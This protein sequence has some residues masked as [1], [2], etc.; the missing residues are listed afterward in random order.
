MINVKAYF[1][2]VFLLLMLSSVGCETA[3]SIKGED[4]T[5]KDVTTAIESMTEAVSGKE[6]SKED[7][8]RF[9]KQL[10]EDGETK[11]VIGVITN[12]LS[13]TDGV[14]KYCPVTGKRY[15]LRLEICPEHNV[16]L[17]LIK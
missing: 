16:L 11:E 13:P 2:S 14:T 7:L 9:K 15:A 10:K 17:E 12:S 1:L 6:L 3:Q 4:E 5:F 8:D